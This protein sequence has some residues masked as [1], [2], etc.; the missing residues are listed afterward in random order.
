MKSIIQLLAFLQ[1]AITP[2]SFI[3][4]SAEPVKSPQIPSTIKKEQSS[5]EG[6]VTIEDGKFKLDGQDFRFVGTNNYYLHY[7]D[8]PMVES[9]ISSAAKGGFN[10]IRTWGFFDGVDDDFNNNH[11]YMQTAANV[12]TPPAGTPSFYVNCWERMDY[13][14]NVAK[15]KGVKLI[16]V[17]TNYWKDFGGVA[18]YVKWADKHNGIDVTDKSYSPDLSKFYTDEYCIA[19]FKNYMNYF[20]NRVNTVNGLT[21][22]DDPT[23]MGFELMNEP[24]N[25]GKD[26]SI[27]TN[28]VKTMTDYLRSLDSKHLIALG[29]EGHFANRADDAYLGLNKDGY[30]GAHGIDY[31]KIIALDNIDFGTY[32]LYPES[33]GAP[34]DAQAWGNKWIK[35]HI[36]ASN[37]V[38]KP[39]L[40]EEFGINAQGQKNR[41][42]IYSNWCQLIYDMNGAGALFWMIAGIDTSANKTKEGYYPD[43]DGYRLVWIDDKTSS[44]EIIALHNYATLFTYGPSFVTF[45]DKVSFL[46]PYRTSDDYTNLGPIEVD[47]DTTPIYTTKV[48]VKASNKKV[49]RVACFTEHRYAGEMTYDQDNDMY[50]FPIELKYYL[51]GSSI[52]IYAK[53]YFE[54]GT[55]LIS[56]MAFIKR[57][58][59]YSMKLD[60]TYEFTSQEDN[61]L[62]VYNYGNSGVESFGE[63]SRCDFNNGAIKASVSSRI[64]T[65]WSEFKIGVKDL[66]TVLTTHKEVDYDV[67][68]RKDLCKPYQGTIPS[69]TEAED[70]ANGFRNYAALDPGWNKLCLNKNNIKAADCEVK[71]VDGVEYYFQTVK[72]PYS[73]SESL[74]LLVLGVVFNYMGF[75]GDIYI[76]NLKFFSK[77]DEG[78]PTDN[79]QERPEIYEPSDEDQTNTNQPSN[80][81]GLIIGLSV[82]GGSIAIGGLS[83]GWFFLFKKKRIH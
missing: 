76:D 70:T 34:E 35:D 3:Q 5:D 52:S 20:V 58:L 8:E 41:E 1:I 9:A 2:L 16:L 77:I 28:W 75:T 69:G 82:G 36:E 10:V 7:K 78:L 22:K 33:W 53:A 13:A 11:A 40:L 6:F 21:Y 15:E 46:A 71:T 74:N 79:Y 14:L 49:K 24:R 37:K 42:V 72:I 67:Y 26:P 59:K 17:F 80:N 64:S 50:S 27:V 18:Q 54:D 39:C 61:G 51:R 44:Y 43:Y 68:I 56:S 83:A 62:T 65:Y 48:S 12:Y 23:I 57:E 31:E 38:N 32:H 19:T 47:S 81:T 55:T 60:K 30:S 45:E 29:D 73:A 63:V 25:P 66:K 4:E